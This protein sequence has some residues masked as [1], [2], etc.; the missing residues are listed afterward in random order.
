MS[1]LIC[2]L[3]ICTKSQDADSTTSFVICEC[4]RHIRTLVLTQLMHPILNALD[5]TP[6]EWI[7]KLLF[8]FN[9]GNIGKFEALAPLFPKEVSMMALLLPHR[10]LREHAQSVRA[11]DVADE[12]WQWCRTL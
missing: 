9:E 10:D 4:I 11:K 6:H 12:R 8:T 1:T 3:Q 5:G 2:H 7:K